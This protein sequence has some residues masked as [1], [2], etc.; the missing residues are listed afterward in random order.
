M[1]SVINEL[2]LDEVKFRR[3]YKR[4]LINQFRRRKKFVKLKKS[5]EVFSQEDINKI[6]FGTTLSEV[7]GRYTHLTPTKNGNYYGRCPFC[8]DLGMNKRSF[9]VS[10]LKNRWKC[11]GC[12]DGGCFTVGFIKKYYNI[13]FDKALRFINNEITIKKIKLESIAVVRS[14]L[15]ANRGSEDN[16]LPF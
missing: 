15:K 2:Y 6:L 5:I 12:G 11:F 4:H 14:R 9:R 13:A 8:R 1:K 10:N 16:G 3:E 7:I